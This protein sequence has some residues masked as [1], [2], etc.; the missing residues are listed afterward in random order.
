MYDRL[1]LTILDR[2]HD[3]I[4]SS[5]PARRHLRCPSPSVLPVL[6]HS[7]MVQPLT[8]TGVFLLWIEKTFLL[9]DRLSVE[10]DKHVIL[11]RTNEKQNKNCTTNKH[12]FKLWIITK[13]K[14]GWPKCSHYH[15]PIFL[16]S[17]SPPT[18]VRLPFP[19]PSSILTSPNCLHKWK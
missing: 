19:V 9:L 18:S 4:V 5:T 11:L 14:T 10:T 13:T 1:P 12:L 8:L 6:S 2:K 15:S 3:G 16:P 17:F 7:L